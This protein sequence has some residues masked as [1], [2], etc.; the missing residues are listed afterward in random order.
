MFGT[1]RRSWLAALCPLT[2]V[3]AACT[4]A[5]PGQPPGSLGT[6]VDR[7]LPSSIAHL[8]LTDQHGASVDLAS[9]RGETTLV[10]PFLT[11]CTDICP[12]DTGNLLQVEAALVHARAAS[13]V[14]LV[15]L[16]IDPGRDTPARL[17]AYAHLTGATWELVTETPA[18]AAEFE[19]YFGWSVQKVPEDSPPSIDWWTGKPLTYDVNHT[20]GFVVFDAHGVERFT[21]GAAPDFRGT[22]NPTLHKF[23]NAQGRDHL[24]HPLKPGWDPV[25]ALSVLGWLL[26]QSIPAQGG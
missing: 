9:F 15:E 23:L 11:L 7:P 8:A 1:R 10:V 5:D 19:A 25:G 4:T 18:E 20:D 6:V 2:L 21:T 17:A 14:H 3:L 26:H 12:L 13:R 24:T 16:S 22:L